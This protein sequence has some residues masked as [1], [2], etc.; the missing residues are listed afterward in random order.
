[1]LNFPPT[2]SNENAVPSSACYEIGS[3]KENGKTVTIH[4]CLND[5]RWKQMYV[6]SGGQVDIIFPNK[7]TVEVAGHFLLHYQGMN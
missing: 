7:A 2:P 5:A 1:M 3:I 4:K 6:S